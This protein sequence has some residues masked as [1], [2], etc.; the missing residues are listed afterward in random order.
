M[1]RNK[2]TE[3]TFNFVKSDKLH[4]NIVQRSPVDV[5]R[6]DV[7]EHSDGAKCVVSFNDIALLFNQERL[8]NLGTDG[9]K[10]FLDNLQKRSGSLA[11]LRKKCSDKDLLALCKSRYIQTPSELLAWSNYLD[12]NYTQ[13]IQQIKED[14][15]I[16]PV[17]DEPNNITVSPNME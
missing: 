8:S 5:V 1:I 11:N 14:N 2:C 4:T 7:I 13:L 16:P 17:V 3:N 6:Y 15:I 10:N 9:V 12:A